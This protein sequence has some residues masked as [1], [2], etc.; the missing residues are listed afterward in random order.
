MN[1]TSTHGNFQQSL[2]ANTHRR[3]TSGVGIIATPFSLMIIIPYGIEIN[4]VVWVQ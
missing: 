4:W 3:A 2:R 1:F